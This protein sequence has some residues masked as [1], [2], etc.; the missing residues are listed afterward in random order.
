MDTDVEMVEK[1]VV[2]NSDKNNNS[3][4]SSNDDDDVIIE[5]NATFKANLLN[6]SRSNSAKSTKSLNNNNTNTN[7][8]TPTDDSTTT[9]Q[10]DAEMNVVDEAKLAE[11][12]EKHKNKGNDSYKTGNY[13]EAIEFYNKAIELCPKSAAYYGNRSA[14]Y[15]MINKY[16]EAIEDAKMSTRLDENFVKGYLREGKAQLCLGDYQSA[17]RCFEKVKQVEP[18]NN[19]VNIDIQNSKAV[20]QFDDLAKEAF[21]KGDF[22]KVVYL[23][24]RSLEHS[25][26]STQFKVL[27]AESLAL[28]GRYQES[29]ELANDIVMKDQMN[30]DA[31][32]VR[33][34]CLYYQDN[35]EK[36]FQHFQRVLQYSP[37][38]T[39][40]KVFY[41]KAKL[42]QAKKEAGNAAFKAGKWQEA[43]DLYTEAM[44]VDILNKSMSSTLYYNRATACS[45]LNKLDACI[46]DCTKAIEIDEGYIKAY[47]RRAKCYMDKEKYDQ[48]IHDYEKVCKLEKTKEH[49]ELLREAKL[50]LKKSKR[51]DYYKILGVAKNATEDE[52][53]KA[54]RKRALMHHPDRFPNETEE[55][56]QEEERKFKE[57]GEAYAVLSDAKKKSRYDNGQDIDEL[58]HD[59]GPGGD[60]DPNI[61]FQAFF[62]GGGSPFMGGGGGG[63]RSRGGFSNQ[64]FQ[65]NFG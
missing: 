22:R 62:G 27:K 1:P 51:K 25:T 26:H 48:A 35:N 17:L 31:I 52:I 50:E 12:A 8:N 19:S 49:Q 4:P 44:A 54:Y 20:K 46:D 11:E 34:M 57:V 45:K 14:A 13:R 47:L 7:T 28:L 43:C 38:H 18:H 36:A 42:L 53:K 6:K 40:A 58:G 33:G 10:N 59:M 64:G 41:K 29:Q 61:L 60:I 21:S 9:L 24:D 3:N 23:M 5:E 56:K 37:D 30:A 65:F 15:L 2:I 63:G 32:Y 16:K 39:K 55:V